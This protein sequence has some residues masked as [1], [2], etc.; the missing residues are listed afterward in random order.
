MI[1]QQGAVRVHTAAHNH[2]LPGFG[3][4]E[5][6]VFIELSCDRETLRQGPVNNAILSLV[7]I[8]LSILAPFRDS[9]CIKRA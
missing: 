6:P 2:T 3:I 1:H 5:N 9:V 7:F 4:S 8:F